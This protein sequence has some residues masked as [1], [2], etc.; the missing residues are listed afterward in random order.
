MLKKIRF[1]LLVC[2]TAVLA[3]CGGGSDSSDATPN[4]AGNYLETFSLTTNSCNLAVQTT[5]TGTDTVTQNGR[6]V[7]IVSGSATFAG[8]V[9]ADNGGFTVNGTITSNGSSVQGTIKY[10]TITVG[11]K[12]SIDYKLVGNGCTTGYTGTATKI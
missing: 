5:F 10:R 3:A 6:N 12:Y 1:L 11:S 8:A 2:I 9:D 7:S 4:F